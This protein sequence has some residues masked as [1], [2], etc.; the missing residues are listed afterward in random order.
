MF[1]IS[2][3]FFADMID[4]VKKTSGECDSIDE[5]MDG[6]L[7]TFC[8]LTPLQSYLSMYSVMVRTSISVIFLSACSANLMVSVAT[9]HTS[10]EGWKF[11]RLMVLRHL[12]HFSL[13]LLR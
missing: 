1:L 12:Y 7:E 3:F 9:F 11:H 5:D 6:S 4:I 13:L 8:S 2:I 10:L